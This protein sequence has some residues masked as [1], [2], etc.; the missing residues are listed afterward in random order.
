MAIPVWTASGWLVAT[1]PV[2][3]ITTDRRVASVPR[4]ST[5]IPPFS[6]FACQENNGP[7]YEK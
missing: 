1:I 5:S 4:S 2:G 3:A 6:L 7:F